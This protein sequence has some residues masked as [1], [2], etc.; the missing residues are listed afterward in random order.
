MTRGLRANFGVG[1]GETVGDS[2]GAAAQRPVVPD[3]ACASNGSS[4]PDGRKPSFAAKVAVP[5]PS[6]SASTTGDPVTSFGIGPLIWNASFFGS[7]PREVIVPAA[8][9]CSLCCSELLMTTAQ[10]FTA[11]DS[12]VLASGRNGT[13]TL[14]SARRTARSLCSSEASTPVM[15]RIFPSGDLATPYAASAT[16]VQLVT[17]RPSR[18]TKKALPVRR[19]WP[20]AS[21]TVIS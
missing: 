3:F 8:T 7:A 17:I 1:D 16:I 12:D 20:L 9:G 13:P 19:S 15:L 4:N 14:V 10:A 11:I 5:T 2:T 6:P 18:E 21:K